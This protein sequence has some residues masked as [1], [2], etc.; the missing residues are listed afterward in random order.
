MVDRHG[1][2]RVVTNLID[3]A[4]K[5]T[6]SGEISVSLQQKNSELEVSVKDSGIGIGLSKE[7][8]YKLFERFYQENV[9][10]PGTGV[11]LSIC[12]TIVEAHGGKIWAES[13]GKG[14]GS[15]FRFTLPLVTEKEP[16]ATDTK[17]NDGN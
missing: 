6:N 10:T 14:E 3:N 13:K 5:Y 4:I 7:Q 8:Q 12:K 17:V 11:G 9:S 16:I 15:T 2:T 1:I